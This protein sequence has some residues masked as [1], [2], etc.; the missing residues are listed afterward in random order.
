[1]FKRVALAI[2]LISVCS[3]NIYS[4]IVSTNNT[5]GL[6][7]NG[8]V[9]T[10]YHFGN[11]YDIEGFGSK[12]FVTGLTDFFG[13][14]WAG[15]I[16]G[17]QEASLNVHLFYRM[18]LWNPEKIL[19]E[20][21]RF[22]YDLF[23]NSKLEFGIGDDLGITGN[24]A[25]A[26]IEFVPINFLNLRFRIGSIYYNALPEYHGFYVFDSL[27][28]DYSIDVFYEREGEKKAG[29]FFEIEPT[30]TFRLLMFSLVSSVKINYQDMFVEGIYYDRFTLFLR[31]N[32]SFSY[33]LN[34][35][36][37]YSALSVNIGFNHGFTYVSGSS[38][39]RLGVAASFFHSFSDVLSIFGE[40]HTGQ[41]LFGYTHIKGETYL[42]MEIGLQFKFF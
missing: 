24:V 39:H 16:Q 26:Y 13:D 2:I 27:E 10:Y 20:D 36:V 42:D 12:D 7:I 31:E 5:R 34:N 37:L 22:A 17:W 15:F 29:Y 19:F 38:G 14:V 35:Y 3:N 40:I 1:M 30:L 41:Y 9:H 33:E 4:M 28:D 23:S 18:P 32:K 8:S 11:Y 25:S 21:T 6:Y